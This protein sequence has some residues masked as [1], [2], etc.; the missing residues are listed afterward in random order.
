MEAQ[1]T[2]LVLNDIR[3]NALG[4]MV[5]FFMFNLFLDFL[6]ARVMFQYHY[7]TAA[8]LYFASV[9]VLYV[10][11]REEHN[12]GPIIYRSLPLAHGKIVM[13]R[14]ISIFLIALACI[15]YG[16]LFRLIILELSPA[17]TQFF[18][19]HTDQL[20]LGNTLAHFLIAQG[21]ALSLIIGIAI[22]LLTRF[23]ISIIGMLA[24]YLASIFIWSRLVNY[25]M[26]YSLRTFFTRPSRWFLFA[27]SMMIVI[28]VVAIRLSVWLYGQRQL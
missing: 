3:L 25:L 9:M 7:V 19:R 24:G 13:A 2:R 14:Y 10:L 1:M 5:V 8:G 18:W 12:K 6:S 22:P 17:H 28:N 23:S 20:A 4:F 16:L 21:L 11:L 26:D 15:G 27:V